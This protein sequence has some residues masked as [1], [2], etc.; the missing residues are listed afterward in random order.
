MSPRGLQ[1]PFGTVRRSVR[2]SS[3]SRCQP[4]AGVAICDTKRFRVGRQS[5]ASR[6]FAAEH[7]CGSSGPANWLW[8]SPVM[9]RRPDGR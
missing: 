7:G 9:R 4:C 2:A 3:L 8:A 6:K 1:P 5:A